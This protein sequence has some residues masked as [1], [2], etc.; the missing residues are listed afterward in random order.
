MIISF[1]RARKR[2]LASSANESRINFV[3]A[4]TIINLSC[5]RARQ[6]FRQT[7]AVELYEDP[8]LEE[9]NPEHKYIE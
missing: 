3:S 5:T 2:F 9:Y 4:V 1:I 6:S 7:R 8:D